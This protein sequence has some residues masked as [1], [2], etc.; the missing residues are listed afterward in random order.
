MSYNILLIYMYMYL[1]YIKI[2]NIYKENYINSD[3]NYNFL[4]QLATYI[5][6]NP[7]F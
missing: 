7:Q 2:L 5:S 1:F 6:I 4:L 3:I